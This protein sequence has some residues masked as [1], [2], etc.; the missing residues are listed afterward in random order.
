MSEA[1][2]LLTYCQQVLA[3]R[4]EQYGGSETVFKAMAQ[5]FSRSLSGKLTAELEPHDAALLMVQ[6]KLARIVGRPLPD[7]PTAEQI[8]V[9]KDNLAD[10]I[11]Y[12]A[13]AWEV[14]MYR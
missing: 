3:Q 6:L 8:K 5:G 9:W 1:S 14:S 7:N 4:G 12:L 11:N 10:A 2:D 13:L